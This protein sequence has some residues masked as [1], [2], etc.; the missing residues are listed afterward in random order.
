MIRP[1]D[2]RALLTEDEPPPL[3]AFGA[4]G[5]SPFLLVCDHAGRRIPRA[6]ESLGL[7]PAALESHIAWDLG[8][9]ELT[10]GLATALDASCVLQTYSRLT[11]DCNRPLGTK[12]SIVRSSG[13]TPVPG[14]QRLSPA[15]AEARARAIFR[16]YHDHIRRELDWRARD[17][18]PTCL[19]AVHSFTPVLLGQD[20]PWHA[21][22]LYRD[23]RLAGPLL[24]LLRQERGL[25]VGDNEPYAVDD[26][27]D[28]T[29]VEHGER[30]GI[31]HVELEL[32]QDLIVDATGRNQWSER[33]ARLLRQAFQELP[34]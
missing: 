4:P 18:R 34:R 15:G 26:A 13:D 16:P 24:R 23:D 5:I 31:P 30:R 17:R 21:G 14:N 8:A 12:D 10:R 6:L 20:R 28:Y 7:S 11:I 9:A 22:V 29:I 33:L 2:D 3:R 25:I 32:R 19:V 27:T 1:S